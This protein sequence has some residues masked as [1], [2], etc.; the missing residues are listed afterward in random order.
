MVENMFK[1]IKNLYLKK[2]K[3]MSKNEINILEW[4][5][6]GIK[7]G[8]DC[9]I[10]S[11][12]PTTRDCFLLTIGNNVTISGNCVFLLH[13]SS[14]NYPSGG[15]FTDLLG[16][17]KIGN[18]CFIG[19]SS[20]ILPGVKLAD[21]IIV[22]AGSVVTKTFNEPNCIIVG[23]PARIVSSTREFAEKNEPFGFMLDG[24]S[25]DETRKEV[26]SKVDKLIKK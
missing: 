16:E 11:N 21:G 25:R 23:N 18:N 7:I 3:H 20:I 4:R 26:L 12:L 6:K 15:K 13:D 19:H 5:K 24:L 8:N 2:V 14:I 17:I 1:K 9:H 22:G 10:Y